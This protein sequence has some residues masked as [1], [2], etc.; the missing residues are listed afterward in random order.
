MQILIIAGPNGAGKSTL[1][2]EI[3]PA[4]IEYVNPDTI[5]KKIGDKSRAGMLKAGRLAIKRRKELALSKVSFAI[6]TT[7]SSKNELLKFLKQ[8]KTNG[9][10]INLLFIWLKTSDLSLE[11]VKER[12]LSGGHDIPT[13]DLKRRH[14][15]SLFNFMMYYSKIAHRWAFYDNSEKASLLVAECIEGKK[16]IFNETEW[17]KLEE[18]VKCVV[19]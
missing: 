16:R 10:Y 7:L 8:E 1:A 3:L 2:K 18:S 13:E 15:R 17:E 14:H 5:A 12:V 9:Y 4:E 11:R 19:D 6:E